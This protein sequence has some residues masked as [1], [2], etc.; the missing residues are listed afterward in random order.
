MVKFNINS[1][2][3]VSY[4]TYKQMF[5]FNVYVGKNSERTNYLCVEKKNWSIKLVYNIE[6]RFGKI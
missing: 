5:K 3:C 6:N 2:A 1:A 4:N